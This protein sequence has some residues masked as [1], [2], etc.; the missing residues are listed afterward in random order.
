MKKLCYCIIVLLFF[1]SGIFGQ[2][3]NQPAPKTFSAIVGNSDGMGNRYVT[4]VWTDPSKWVNP[5]INGQGFKISG[6]VKNTPFNQYVY[7]MFFPRNQNVYSVTI[8][9]PP[10]KYVFS[11]VAV[12]SGFPDSNPKKVA[13]T[14]P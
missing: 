6:I 4:L 14:V 9:L 3:Q 1:V 5:N 11:A 12:S 7:Y 8:L 13:F 10:N 2:N